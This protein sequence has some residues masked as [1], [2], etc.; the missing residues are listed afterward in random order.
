[1]TLPVDQAQA[2]ALLAEGKTAQEAGAA[3]LLPLGRVV[4]LARR[5]GWT[6]HPSSGLAFDVAQD[7]HKP[8]LADDIAAIASRWAD[9]PATVIDDTEDGVDELLAN[10]RACDDRQVRAALGKAETAIGRLRELYG[11]AAERIAEEQ[12]REA[13]RLAA[14]AEIAELERK[15]AGARQR[16]K[17]IGAK[18]A[19]RA[20]QQGGASAKE[21]RAWARERGIDVPDIGRVSR[22]LR[23]Q[24]E[25]AQRAVAS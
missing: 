7:D 8:V 23:D 15:L 5:Q 10:A 2:L 4:Q 9:R 6:I 11:S 25:A 17:D 24:Y 18:P 16:A 1:V 22:D 14:L 3:T 12:A 20:D 19:H 21:V 13:E